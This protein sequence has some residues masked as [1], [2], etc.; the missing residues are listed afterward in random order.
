[1]LVIDAVVRKNTWPKPRYV[2]LVGGRNKLNMMLLLE[3]RESRPW[4]P[5]CPNAPESHWAQGGSSGR[6]REK[7]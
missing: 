5:K 4:T 1:M 3:H 7:P 6:P 2:L